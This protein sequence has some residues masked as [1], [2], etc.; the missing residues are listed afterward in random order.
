MR[1]ADRRSPDTGDMSPHLELV[2]NHRKR[3]FGR[4]R[5]GVIVP[6]AVGVQPGAL[7]RVEVRL[8]VVGSEIPEPQGLAGVVNVHRGVCVVQPT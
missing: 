1:K 7:L 3:L 4:R 8:D 5:E 2:V 6:E